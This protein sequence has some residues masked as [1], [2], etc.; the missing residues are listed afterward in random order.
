MNR[1]RKVTRWWFWA[2]IGVVIILLAAG[3]WVG[4]RGIQA[5]DQLQEAQGLV[6]QLKTQALSG[7]T[8][9]AETTLTALEQHS[10]RARELTS[11]PV[12]RAAEIVPV[13]G[14]NLAA[15]R[16]LAVV[17]DNVIDESVAPLMKVMSTSLNPKDLA[18]K[19]G[20]IDISTFN[21]AV[22][23]VSKA[24]SAL[25]QELKSVEAINTSSTIGP[26]KAAKVKL[27][28][29]LRTVSPLTQTFARVLPMLAPALGADA[30]RHYLVIFENNAEARSLGGTALSSALITVDKGHIELTSM[31]PGTEFDHYPSSVIPVPDGVEQIYGDEFGTFIANNTVRPDFPSAAQMTAVMWK[32]QFGQQI[33]GV[34]SIDPVALSYI[35]RAL[36]PMKLSSG[37]VLSSNTLVPLLLNTVYEQYWTKPPPGAS[38]ATANADLLADNAAQGEVYS[39]AIQDTFSSL[40]SGQLKPSTLAY[41][42]IQAGTER[43]L[44]L[45]SSHADEQAEYV[46]AGIAG[47]L[48]QSN[49]KTAR[50]GVYFQDDI[51]SKMDYYLTQSVTVGQAVCRADKRPNYQITAKLTNTAPDDSATALSP[52]ILGNTAEDG[53]PAGY[54]RMYVYLYAP[55]GSQITAATANGVSVP[56]SGWHDTNYPVQRVTVLFAPGATETVTFDVVAAGTGSKALEAEVTPMVHATPVT[57]AELNCATVPG[58]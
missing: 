17:T 33:D 20:A 24:S 56:I 48:P 38:E 19:D 50:V 43:R 42:L 54:Q 36:P 23:P 37:E 49:A 58:N 28:G 30:P 14:P 44:M 29:L 25:A 7:N 53:I 12:W 10:A 32:Q 2:P 6:S 55:P 11:D 26:V 3:A 8:H 39:Q 51:G 1:R 21:G 46:K 15:V 31:V 34:I 40:L 4:A 22:G 57:D 35:L 5:K 52:S 9:G 45:W 13:I 47:L 18:P 27:A 16:Q 41:A